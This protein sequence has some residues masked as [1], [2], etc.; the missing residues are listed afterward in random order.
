MDAVKTESKTT[1]TTPLNSIGHREEDKGRP[2]RRGVRPRL[3]RQQ[4]QSTARSRARKE[5]R[6]QKKNIDDDEYDVWL[7]ATS[8][9]YASV[10]YP[11]LLYLVVFL[12]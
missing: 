1:L 8:V 12:N 9:M 5:L 7:W 6:G 4:R 11:E 2:S 10:M 3:G